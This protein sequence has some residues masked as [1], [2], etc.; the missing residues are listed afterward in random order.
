MNTYHLE[1][2]NPFKPNCVKQVIRAL[3]DKELEGVKYNPETCTRLCLTLSEELR[4]RIK[5]LGYDRCKLVCTV[6]I[7]E[8]CS[9][10]VYSVLSF[11]WDTEHDN[12]AFYT[13]ENSYIYAVACVY[14]VYYE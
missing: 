1:A 7:G 6:E 9:Q 14:G 2:K 11:L 4:S 3:I 5:V 12:Y 13:Y 8:K 10:S